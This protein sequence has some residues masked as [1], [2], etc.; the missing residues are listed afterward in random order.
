MCQKRMGETKKKKGRK[1]RAD[2]Y[3]P[4][5]VCVC[6]CVCVCV[7]VCVYVCVFVILSLSNST[8][9]WEFR[10][11]PEQ[12]GMAVRAAGIYARTSTPLTGKMSSKKSSKM[13]IT[14]S[15]KRAVKRAVK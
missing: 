2:R 4:A 12:R 7:C 9:C 3:V 6:L 13:S 8:C 5:S 1:K 10:D 11:V 15:S 14:R